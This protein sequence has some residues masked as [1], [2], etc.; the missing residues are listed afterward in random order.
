MDL[1]IIEDILKKLDLDSGDFSAEQKLN[2]MCMIFKEVISV[3]V[4]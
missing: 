1:K 3:N 2:A 4:R